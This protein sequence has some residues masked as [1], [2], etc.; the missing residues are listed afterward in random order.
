MTDWPAIIARLEGRRINLR[1]ILQV[2]RVTVWYWRRGLR[3]PNG[4]HA[5]TIISLDMSCR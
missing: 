5:A 3:K 4:D 2:S 1:G